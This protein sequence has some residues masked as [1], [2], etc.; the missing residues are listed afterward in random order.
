MHA[1]W[2]MLVFDENDDDRISHGGSTMSPTQVQ[3]V[4]TLL[5]DGE[6]GDRARA[7]VQAMRNDGE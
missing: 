4:V 2:V 6:E 7:D 3:R 5:S 1:V